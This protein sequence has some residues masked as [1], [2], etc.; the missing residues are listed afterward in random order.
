M[1]R[2]GSPGR[3]SRS[4]PKTA[5]AKSPVDQ[6]HHPA[7]DKVQSVRQAIMEDGGSWIENGGKWI[8][9]EAIDETGVP[10]PGGKGSYMRT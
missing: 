9:D 6:D 3:L 7:S 1:D 2:I 5:F 10:V 8:E 4:W